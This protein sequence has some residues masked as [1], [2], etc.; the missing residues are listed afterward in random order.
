MLE[1]FSAKII[2]AVVAVIGALLGV[3]VA[4]QKGRK[5]KATEVQAETAKTVIETVEK[6]RETEDNVRALDPDERRKRLRQYARD[7]K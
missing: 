7:P 5:A 3:V 4:Y 6:A 2:A 1:V